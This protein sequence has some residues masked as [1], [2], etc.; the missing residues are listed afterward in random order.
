LDN[1]RW[2]WWRDFNGGISLVEPVGIVDVWRT[3]LEITRGQFV[4]ISC[5]GQ[6]V[7][8]VVILFHI[9]IATIGRRFFV[10]RIVI[11]IA[12]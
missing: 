11:S 1:R 12:L 7:S 6:F 3:G 2:W 10:G 9:G 8:I 4:L 5:F